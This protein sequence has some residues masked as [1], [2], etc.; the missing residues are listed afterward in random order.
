MKFKVV[1]IGFYLHVQPCSPLGGVGDGVAEP[2]DIRVD[3]ER[4]G[5]AYE[6]TL[7]GSFGL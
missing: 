7:V 6:T 1:I 2:T 5:L 4:V 3:S